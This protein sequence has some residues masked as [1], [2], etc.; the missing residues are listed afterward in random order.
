MNYTNFQKYAYSLV[1]ALMLVAVAGMTSNAQAQFQDRD[2]N[3]ERGDDRQRRDNYPNGGYDNNDRYGNNN[4]YGNNGRNGRN[5]EY[6]YKEEQK[7]SRDG[8][9]HGKEDAEKHRIPDPNNTKQYRNGS[10]PYRV[11]FRQ[12]YAQ[13]YRQFSPYRRRW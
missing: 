13:S 3:R 10:D 7:G 1:V 8:M 9:R 11:G 5:S 2:W 12:A 6:Y 4:G